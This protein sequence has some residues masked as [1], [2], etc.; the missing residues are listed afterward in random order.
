MWTTPDRHTTAEAESAGLSACGRSRVEGERPIPEAIY[1]K[2]GELFSGCRPARI[3]TVLGS[4]VAVTM[5]DRKRHAAAICHAIQPICRQAAPNCHNRCSDRYRSVECAVHEMI[6]RMDWMGGSR[7]ELEIKIFGGA[8]ILGDRP[9][10]KGERSVG[11]QNIES[12]R[13][14]LAEYGLPIRAMVVG[15]GVGRQIIFVTSNGS[16]FL[17]RIA[18]IRGSG[19]APTQ[20]KKSL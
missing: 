11:G 3:T 8:A 10:M 9:G 2:P 12:A 14:V 16:V 5:Y 20:L 13:R 7:D 17:K 6:R 15:G 19:G 4:C 18:S 1:L